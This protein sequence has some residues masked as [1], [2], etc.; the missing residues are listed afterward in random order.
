[1]DSQ[2]IVKRFFELRANNELCDYAITT[3]DDVVFKVHKTYI[4]VT[5][6]YFYAMLHSAVQ[7][8][9]SRT[10]SV[11][12][13]N[14]TAAGLGPVLDFMYGVVDI[15]IDVENVADVLNAAS[16]LQIVGMFD[17]CEAFLLSAL[18]E[19]NY[20]EIRKLCAQFAMTE[21]VEKLDA[22][23]ASLGGLYSICKRHIGMLTREINAASFLDLLKRSS[24]NPCNK[25]ECID[26]YINT[27]KIDTPSENLYNYAFFIFCFLLDDNQKE[28]VVSE[29]GNNDSNNQHGWFSKIQSESAAHLELPMSEQVLIHDGKTNIQNGDQGLVTVSRKD[30]INIVIPTYPHSV[31]A[32]NLRWNA[33]Y[34]VCKTGITSMIKKEN[35][36]L[37]LITVVNNF[38]ILVQDKTCYLFNPRNMKLE[39]IASF[40]EKRQCL[41]MLSHASDVFAIVNCLDEDHDI[42]MKYNFVK[43]VWIE[44]SV[45]PMK[46]QEVS[47]QVY[48]DL[49]YIT[50]LNLDYDPIVFFSI[51][52]V[53]CK[54]TRLVDLP[55]NDSTKLVVYDDTLY[56]QTHRYNEDFRQYKY[57]TDEKKWH[58]C[59]NDYQDILDCAVSVKCRLAIGTHTFHVNPIGGLYVD[60]E[61]QNWMCRKLLRSSYDTE[62]CCLTFPEISLAC[63]DKPAIWEKISI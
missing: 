59:Q 37:P 11:K 27:S 34:I 40:D 28:S 54:V 4:A 62:M 29:C 53:T 58:K 19:D 10:N 60:C 26:T 47:G 5:S 21:T 17:K 57:L 51:E 3:C 23:I 8:L 13:H 56:C 52:P 45:I 2:A 33:E 44:L 22:K 39:E 20:L 61:K 35:R 16:I 50:G 31:N 15:N 48:Q 38:M 25:F 14:V 46:M 32:S 41:L 55:V 30:G 36:H 49:L 6:D 24:I 9:E 1:M 18:G 42:V 7:M 63:V 43:N 12:L